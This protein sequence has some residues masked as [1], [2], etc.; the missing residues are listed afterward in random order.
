MRDEQR[1]LDEAWWV[2]HLVVQRVTEE[3][4]PALVEAISQEV[5]AALGGPAAQRRTRPELALQ[6]PRLSPARVRFEDVQGM[7]DQ[8][9]DQETRAVPSLQP[10]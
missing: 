6:R 7:I 4:V 1:R 10:V 9:L 3:V 5:H 2:Q 8:V